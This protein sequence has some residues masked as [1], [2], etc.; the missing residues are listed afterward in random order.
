M[1]GKNM[2][3]LARLGKNKLGWVEK[4]KPVAGPRDAIVKPLAFAPCTSDVHIVWGDAYMG[5]DDAR[6]VG[7]ESVG[8]V[9]EVGSEVRDFKPGDRVIVP[10]ITPTWERISAQNGFAQHCDGMCTGMPFITFKDGTFAE[11]FHVNDADANLAIL[12]DELTLEQAVMV[13]DMMTTGFYGAELADIKL[14]STVAV[15]GIGPVGLM[16]VA[17]AE[18]SGAARILAVGSRP[19]SVKVAKEYGATD[20]IDYHNGDTVQQIMDLTDGNGVDSAVVAGGNVNTLGEAVDV[21]KP[22]GTIGNVNHY[23]GAEFIPLPMAGWGAGLSD[24][25]IKGG[26]CPGGRL[27]MERLAD[28]VKYGRIDPSKLIS[29]RFTEFD[30]LE[31]ALILMKDKPRDLIKPA[32]ILE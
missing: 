8:V 2:K 1:E 20:I 22:G 26:L 17:G 7:H 6:I 14:G 32:V 18:L 24:K 15:F 31:E 9:E 11:F 16:G 5:D 28:L 19:N 4:D 29:H 27:R 30:D 23:E 3:G 21:L 12:P 10:A 25:T 13:P